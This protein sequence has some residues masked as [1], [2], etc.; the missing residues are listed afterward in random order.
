M[1][2]DC[3]PLLYS[4]AIHSIAGN[5][6]SREN[7]LVEE[8]GPSESL[9]C[10]DFW[11]AGIIVYH[12]Y[13]LNTAWNIIPMPMIKVIKIKQQAI[14]SFVVRLL[15][16]FISTFSSVNLYRIILTTHEDKDTQIYIDLTV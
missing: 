3:E 1:A 2:S 8:K 12:H 5:H 10:T 13:A 4:G 16:L 9:W 11:S 6:S 7:S 14:K 15:F